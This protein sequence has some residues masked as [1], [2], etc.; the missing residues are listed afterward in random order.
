MCVTRFSARAAGGDPKPDR[1][2]QDAYSHEVISA[3]FWPGNGGFGAASFYCYAAPVPAGL[4][5]KPIQPGIWNAEMGE[6]LLPCDEVREAADPAGAVMGFLEST[7][8]A[9]AD[10]AH[11]DRAALERK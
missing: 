6:F 5:D 8:A 2:Q 11:W 3:G 4:G 7:Y 10:C 9:A 1:V